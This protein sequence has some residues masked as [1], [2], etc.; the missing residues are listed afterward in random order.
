MT[1]ACWVGSIVLELAR[2]GAE[3]LTVSLHP[4]EANLRDKARPIPEPAPVTMALPPRNDI[5]ASTCT[6]LDSDCNSKI[7]SKEWKWRLWFSQW[8][9]MVRTSSYSRDESDLMALPEDVQWR[10]Q[11]GR[12]V[13]QNRWAGIL[14]TSHVAHRRWFKLSAR[15]TACFCLRPSR[16]S[17][18]SVLSGSVTVLTFLGLKL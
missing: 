14:T 3:K 13:H 7:V 8:M 15:A 1:L 17:W 9:S 6:I 10:N 11:V 12:W 5:L 2:R 18:K 16:P 4:C